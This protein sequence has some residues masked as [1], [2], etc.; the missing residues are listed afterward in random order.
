M[1]RSWIVSVMFAFIGLAFLSACSKDADSKANFIFKP[2]PKEGVV[3]KI[4]DVEVTEE[5]ML[6]SIEGQVYDAEVKL[7]ELKMGRIRALVLK[8]L[9]DADPKKKGLS[10][11]EFLEKYIASTVKVTDKDINAFIE[12]RK[13]PKENINDQIKEKVR[14]FLEVE[15]KKEAIENWIGQKTKKNPIEVYIQEPKRPVYEVELGNAP[16]TGGADAKVTIVEFSDFQCPFCAKGAELMDQVK[17]KYGNKVKIAFKNYPLPFHTHAKDA[18]HA[19]L[20]AHEQKAEAFWKMH[21]AMF[22]DQTKLSR[23]DLKASAKKIGINA[24]DF[25]K[26]MASNKFMAAIEAD[27]EQGKELGVQSTPTFFVNG[28]LVQGAYPIEVFSEI[29]DKELAK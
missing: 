26:C 22:G 12:E 19:S 15:K 25:D 24:E 7:H 9:M 14:Q 28:Q 27:V 20:C 17:K 11:D 2:A 6:K 8:T 21:D 13:I 29:I 18:A 4:G 3:A 5:E 16:F 1:K 10:N 23:E